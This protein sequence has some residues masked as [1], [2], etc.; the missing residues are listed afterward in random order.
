M[1][2][3]AMVL[4]LA[5]TATTALA[6]S[7]RLEGWAGVGLGAGKRNAAWSGAVGAGTGSG[8]YF[9]A[10]VRYRFVAIEARYVG[11]SFTADSAL[12]GS[13]K[14]SSR[15]LFASV[16]PALAGFEIGYGQRTFRGA[17]A[18]R[19]WSYATVG[20]RLA[21]PVGSSG[22]VAVAR[23]HVY[24]GAKE[25]GGA[26]TATGLAGETAL[27]YRLTSAPLFFMLGYRVERFI[28]SGTPSS[29]EEMTT[30]ILG[31]GVHF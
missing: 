6:Q 19:V 14:V 9:Q 8:P 5:L 1:R 13:G 10:G 18:Q 4:A 7:P 25:S 21:V 17:L 29:P 15:E 27:R 20:G 11:A 12:A 26:T 16:G 24:A 31:A 22:L 2:P 30:V 23:L 28:V 3:V